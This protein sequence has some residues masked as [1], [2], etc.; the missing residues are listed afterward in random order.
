VAGGLLL[1]DRHLK[2]VNDLDPLLTP[3][4]HAFQHAREDLA[5]H[6]NGLSIAQIWAQPH[7]LAPLGYHLRHIAGSVE[8]LT[9]Y[10]QGRQLDER[11]MRA[12]ETEQQAGS[13]REELL[14]AI[15]N[16]FRGAEAVVRGLDPSRLA[17]R[18]SVGRKG[19]P[20]TVIGL[21]THIAEHTLRHV[22]QAVTT[23]KVLRSS[24]DRMVL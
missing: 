16:A 14:A 6:T 8:R 17:E 11:Q 22:G 5:G 24:E 23:I 7:G 19:L 10:L 3:L 2:T 9:T 18:R 4:I 12:L 21:L 1:A 20:T 15:D 13:D